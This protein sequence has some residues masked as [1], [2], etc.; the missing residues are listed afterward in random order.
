MTIENMTIKRNEI[1]RRR[2]ALDLTLV[3]AATKAGWN[4][5]QDWKRIEDIKSDL[6]ISTLQRVAKVLGCTVDDLLAKS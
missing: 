2:K 4:N 6:R 5:P 3:A 1:K